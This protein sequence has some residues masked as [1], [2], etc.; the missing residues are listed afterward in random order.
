V[1]ALAMASLALDTRLVAPLVFAVACACLGPNPFLDDDET[2]T[3]DQTGDGDGDG[4][5]GSCT[6]NVKNGD[7][8][9]IDCGGSCPPCDDGLACVEPSD[10]SSGVCVGEICQA[11]SCDDEVQNGDELGVDCGGPDCGFC[12]H[13]N[14]STELDDFEGSA[15]TIPQVAMFA[16]RSFALTYNG[17]MQARAR[18]FDELGA[19]QGPGVELSATVQFVGNRRIPLFAGAGDQHPIHTLEAGTDAMSMSTDLFLIHRTPASEDNTIRINALNQAV[20]EGDL[21]VDGS[22]VAISWTLNKQ[23]LTRRLDYDVADGAWIDISAFEAEPLPTDF[24]GGQPAM[25]RNAAGVS[26]VAWVRCASGGFPCDI[27]VRRF[28]AGWIDPAPVLAPDLP[29][30]YGLGELQVAIADDG[31]VGVIWTL[32]DIDQTSVAA[33]LLDAELMSEGPIWILQADIP[34]STA[35]DVAALSDGSF[36]FVWPDTGQDRVHLRRFVGPDM[37]K[38]P[39][40]GDES[41][42]PVVD[43]PRFAS[44]AGVDGRL[45]VVWSAIVDGVSQIQGQV[46]SY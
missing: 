28:D 36:A 29:P 11:P 2:T 38:L 26:V 18:W 43:T 45:V 20:S 16:D 24:E 34:S 39:D 17:P 15:A 8:T 9:A 3:V 23:I 1:M 25:A 13:G 7:E 35:G 33:W 31:R 44:I 19:P 4:E 12:Q 5:P 42:W 27:A 21:T 22:Q 32:I 40:V 10:C 37:P 30:G 41:P 46:L 6:D 14:F